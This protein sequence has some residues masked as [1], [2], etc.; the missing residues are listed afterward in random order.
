MRGPD[1][2]YRWYNRPSNGSPPS[3][4]YGT[5]VYGGINTIYGTGYNGV[6]G[7]GTNGGYGAI[8]NGAFGAPTATPN[9]TLIPG[10]NIVIR[11]DGSTQ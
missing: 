7:A 9:S 3:G 8:T 11:P 2:L 5:N 4:A 10:S 6:F 1:G